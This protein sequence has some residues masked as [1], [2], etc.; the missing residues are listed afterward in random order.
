M[1][2]KKNL[3]PDFFIIGAQKSATTY[4]HRCLS[5]HPDIGIFSGGISY[6]SDPEYN[7]ISVEEYEAQFTHLKLKKIIGHKKPNF[8][9]IPEVAHRLYNYAPNAKLIVLL[10][11]PVKRAISAYYHLMRHGF[12]PA[13]SLKKG[14][15]K[16]LIGEYNK[17]YPK[18]KTI[19]TSGFYNEHLKRF[20]QYFKKEQILILI[21]EDLFSNKG[22]YINKTYS[23]LGIDAFVPPCLN[24]VFNQG[25][26]SLTLLR[27]LNCLNRFKCQTLDNSQRNQFHPR[28]FIYL[29]M[30][31]GL[32]GLDR[33][34]LQFILNQGNPHVDKNL[35]EK[36]FSIYASDINSLE[37]MLNKDLT[38]WKQN[39]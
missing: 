30:F 12:L 33:A 8:L 5:E 10:R 6:F 24:E 3:S 23:F 29:L 1:S 7:N 2:T 32:H 4:L 14:M 25:I 9:S 31:Y 34:L 37:K 19:I 16:V 22:F 18:A 27:W 21:Q 15:N 36:L 11:D 26:Y 13:Q 38:I 17:M 35:T 20:W 28:N 39:R